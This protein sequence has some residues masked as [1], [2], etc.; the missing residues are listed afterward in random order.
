M[1]T[2]NF[3]IKE[4]TVYNVYIKLR[5]LISNVMKSKNQNSYNFNNTLMFRKASLNF[6]MNT[7]TFMHA[8]LERV[9][10]SGWNTTWNGYI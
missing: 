8:I 2:I 5:C 6:G 9:S 7:W 1:L 4:Y 10:K 3:K